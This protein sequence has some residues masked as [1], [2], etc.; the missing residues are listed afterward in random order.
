[1]TKK[2]WVYILRTSGNTLY[3]GQTNNLEKRFL[4]H[5]NGK[6]GHYTRSHK[7]VKFYCTYGTLP[8]VLKD[9][10]LV[11]QTLYSYVETYLRE[12]IKEEAGRRR[13]NN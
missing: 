5:K 3:T 7:P 9:A 1:M 6:G 2:F 10:D 8:I 12:E 4:D 11:E 13:E